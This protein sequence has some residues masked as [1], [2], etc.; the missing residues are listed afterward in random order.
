MSLTLLVQS[1]FQP[2]KHE[3]RKGLVGFSIGMGIVFKGILITIALLGLAVICIVE[4]GVFLGFL[5]LPVFMLTLFF[6]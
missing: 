6:R 3:Y 4:V 2:L 1:F 5:L